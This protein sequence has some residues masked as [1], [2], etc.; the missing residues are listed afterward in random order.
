MTKS[1]TEIGA[2]QYRAFTFDKTENIDEE[3]RTIELSFSSDAEIRIWSD[4]VQILGHK[5]GEYNF[6]FLNDGA[7]LLLEHN[8]NNQ[9]GVVEKA[10]VEDNKGR[11]I[12][13]FSRSTLA[14]EIFQDFIDGIRS[15]ISVGNYIESQYLLRSDEDYNTF[16]VD[17]W[18]SFEISVGD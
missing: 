13:R 7:P 17:K 10:W 18:T 11:A 8:R 12:V 6:D 1:R 4:E 14:Q 5:D 16:Y 15:K 2:K 9:I 3:K